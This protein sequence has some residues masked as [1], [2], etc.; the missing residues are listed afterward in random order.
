[1]NMKKYLWVSERERRQDPSRVGLAQ[2]AL[3]ML[4]EMVLR[5]TVQLADVAFLSRI[6]DSV[7]NAVSVSSQYIMLCMIIG[8]AVATGTIVCINQAIGMKNLQKVNKLA[9]I[10]VVVNTVIGLLFGLLFLVGADAMLVIMALEDAALEAAG[11]Y[12]RIVGGLMVF[13]TVS[14]I[15]NSLCR[16]MGHTKAPLAI[17][18]TVNII[19]L[20][21]NYI[22]VFHPELVGHID[23]VV[24]VAIASVLGCVGGMILSFVIVARSGIRLSLRYLRPFP[25]EDFRLALSIGI[26][27]GMNNLAYSLSQLVT[28]SIVSLTGDTMMAAKVYV[29]N[30]VHYVALVGWAFSMANSTMVG[31]RVGAGQYDEAKEIRALVTR[32]ALLSNMAF[33][34]LI[35]AV[36]RPLMGLFTDD[37]MIL[38]LAAG[39]IVIDFVVEIGRALNNSI[40]G[41]LQAAGDVKY[42]LVVNQASGWIVSVGGSYLLGIVMGWGLY[43]VWTAFALDEMLRGLILLRRW[44]SDKWMIGA[45]AHRRI[46]AKD[47]E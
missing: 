20:T 14:I 24:G 33:S 13:Q 17:N 10:T 8:T 27:G 34:L 40:S 11:R 39:V 41:A 26:P 35:I 36:N 19:N 47:H 12:M 31:Y 28:T 6:S 45:E 42:Q 9:S 3:P 18:L 15:L 29:S 25:V 44:K 32:I 23:P 43:G 38:K 22:V 4:L 21:G 5:S 7:V 2:L 46:I 30:I 37:P 16:S 1:M